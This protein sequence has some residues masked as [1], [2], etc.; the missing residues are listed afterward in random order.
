MKLSHPTTQIPRPSQ[1]MRGKLDGPIRYVP[2][3]EQRSLSAKTEN[4][5]PKISPIQIQLN[6]TVLHGSLCLCSC[7]WRTLIHRARA[8]KPKIAGNIVN[9]I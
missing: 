4:M 7:P 1:T 6:T 2:L 9:V 5:I 3:K 8:P